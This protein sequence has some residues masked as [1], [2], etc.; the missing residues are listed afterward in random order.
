MK[1]AFVDQ[2]IGGVIRPKRHGGSIQIIIYELARRL[3]ASHEIIVYDRRGPDQPETETLEGVHFRRLS[4]EFMDDVPFRVVRKFGRFPD[5]RRPLFASEWYH[6]GY[7]NRI[8]RDLRSQGCQ[9]VF[10]ANM[11]QYPA[12]IRKLNPGIC[13]V[14]DMQCEWLNQLD[15]RLVSE[16][17]EHVDL[18]L[19]CSDF[20]TQKARA[21]LP[22]HAARCH[23]LRNGYD[24]EQFQ[25]ASLAVSGTKRLLY[26]G[27][28]TPE[29]GV[30]VLIEAFRRIADRYPEAEL[31][32]VGPEDVTPRSFVVAIS[33]NPATRDLERWQGRSYIAVLKQSVPPSLAGRVHFVGPVPHEQTASYYCNSYAYIHPSVWN[34]PMAVPLFEATA[35]GLPVIATCTGGTPEV[36]VHGETGLLVPANDA[37]A[38]A[39]AMGQLLSD[40]GLRDRMSQAGRQWAVSNL[41]WDRA[42]ARLSDY[43]HDVSY[44]PVHA[45]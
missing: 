39:G 4:S 38:L 20:I 25:P 35:S 28:L 21:A 27:R 34:E 44:A 1:I 31:D 22:E 30:H 9:V 24:A 5:P 10:V 11:L 37:E 16:H 19:G 43:L 23:T 29:K 15:R 42:A 40:P 12:I 13:I 45:C 33:D 26:V 36:V 3:A 32:I 2:P 14:L 17:L 41:S 6:R 18:I 7:I 8:A